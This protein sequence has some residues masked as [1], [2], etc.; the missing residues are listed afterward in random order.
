M[1]NDKTIW[2]DFK[3]GDSNSLSYIYNQHVDF[4]Y[5]YGSKFTSNKELIKDSIQDLFLDLIRTRDNLGITD[6][7]RFYLTCSFRNKLFRNMKKPENLTFSENLVL[8]QANIVYSLEK[9][10]INREDNS[11]RAEMIRKAL[12]EISPRQR[13]ILF[14]RFNCEFSYDQICEIMSLKY[15]SARKLVFR[16]LKILKEKLQDKEIFL[17]FFIIF[18]M[19]YCTYL[20]SFV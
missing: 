18:L 17:F 6:N 13:E 2:K 16:A 7:I 12:K 4:L 19:K 5:N 14:Y 20:F 11:G 1:K 10:I 8:F 9:D 3:S 15:D